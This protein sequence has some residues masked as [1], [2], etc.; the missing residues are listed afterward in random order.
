M[1]P[2]LRKKSDRD[3][4]WHGIKSGFVDII[5]TDHA[6]HSLNEKKSKFLEAPNGIPGLETLLPLM[7][8]YINKKQITLGKFI[9]LSSEN[10]A[11]IFSI[12]NKGRILADYDADLVIVDLKKKSKINPDKFYSKAQHSPFNGFEVQGIP[13]MTILAGELV[14]DHGEILTKEGTGSII[15]PQN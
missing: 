7:L 14:M 2:P 6:P 4:L 11:K 5:A 8:T 9:E 13:I 10:P 12:Q 15:K 1:V 3:M